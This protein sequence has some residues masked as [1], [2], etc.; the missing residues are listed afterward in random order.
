MSCP[1]CS[2]PVYTAEEV[3]FY[4]RSFHKLCFKCKDCNKLLTLGDALEHDADPYCKIHHAAL[5]GAPAITTHIHAGG[6]GLS[7]ARIAS[8]D[9]RG[10]RPD[11]ADPLKAKS[12]VDEKRSGVAA[13][14]AKPGTI[15]S[16]SAVQFAEANRRDLAMQEEDDDGGDD[17]LDGDS[18]I[19]SVRFADPTKLAGSKVGAGAADKYKAK[20]LAVGGGTA[21]GVC[22]KSVGFAEKVVFLGATWH[23]GTCFKCDKCGKGLNAQA[24]AL[25]GGGKPVCK[26]CHPK[27]FGGSKKF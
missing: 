14:V 23:K 22:G 15:R 10:T 24:E 12:T 4:G 16:N 19:Q 3:K 25:E 26:S 13:S 20:E 7:D 5:F 11:F 27:Y 8:I 9:M 18:R 21:C 6:D 1:T 17:W 2:K